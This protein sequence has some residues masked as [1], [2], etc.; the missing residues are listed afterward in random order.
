MSRTY[1]VSEKVKFEDVIRLCQAAAD[2]FRQLGDCKL[3]PARC[4]CTPLLAGVVLS[5][6]CLRALIVVAIPRGRSRAKLRD[7]TRENGGRIGMDACT[8]WQETIVH[9]ISPFTP[10]R[11]L[12]RCG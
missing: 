1:I 2:Q 8:S 9:P 12:P 3:Q 7:S 6:V 5:A 4:R 10:C 11:R